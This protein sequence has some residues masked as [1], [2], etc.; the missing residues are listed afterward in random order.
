MTALYAP[1]K[2]LSV[3]VLFAI[4]S[5]L[6]FCRNFKHKFPKFGG[7]K[8]LGQLST[9]E[10]L[11][12]RSQLEGLELYARYNTLKFGGKFPRRVHEWLFGSI[13]LF[14]PKNTRLVVVLDQDVETD[15]AYGST[16]EEAN[17]YKE[18]ELIKSLLHGT[19]P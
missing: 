3:V 1:K 13:S 5:I 10:S 11:P 17:R 7:S 9:D 14:W 2:L 18:I 19:I 6:L 4:V 16:L 15:R 12:S 8:A